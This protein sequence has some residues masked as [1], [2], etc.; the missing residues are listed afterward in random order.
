[1]AGVAVHGS[2]ANKAVALTFDADMTPS[3]LERL[4]TGRVASWYDPRIVE[5]LTAVHADATFFLTGLWAQTYPDVVRA[6]AG[7]PSF[8]IENHS[9]D[10]A[11]W[12]APCYGLPTVSGDQAKR[13]ELVDAA[14][15]INAVAGVEASFFRFP[16]GCHDDA[17][18]EL[19]RSL[20]E[21]P[22]AW[23]VIS[24]DSFNPDAA[25]IEAT[26]LSRVKPGS[27]VVMHLMGAPNAPATADALKG[28]LS[29]LAERGY[30]FVTVRAMLAP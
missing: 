15:A 5:E 6:L 11:A 20:G 14:Q 7:N 26:V 12:R 24:G 23:D 10:H 17:D 27:I 19:V 8:E 1:V 2:R 22:V 4:R 3:M 30:S 18:V 29:H 9:F 25:S 28:I 13:T 21:V 16:G